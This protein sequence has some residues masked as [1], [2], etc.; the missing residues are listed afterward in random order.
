MSKYLSDKQIEEQY[1]HICDDETEIKVLFKNSGDS[2]WLEMS[3]PQNVNKNEAICQREDFHDDM[4]FDEEKTERFIIY[5]SG[6]IAFDE[7][8]PTKV[9]DHLV[10]SIIEIIKETPK[11]ESQK[12][13]IKKN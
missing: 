8:Y 7:W 1:M 6:E 13:A 10:K 5:T 9:Y 12:E 4:L 11:T 3:F 2:G